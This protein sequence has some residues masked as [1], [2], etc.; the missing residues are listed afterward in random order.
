MEGEKALEVYCLVKMS[1]VDG[2][3]KSVCERSRGE[4]LGAWRLGW[5][6]TQ[7]L[8]ALIVGTLAPRVEACV[9]MEHDRGR[10]QGTIPDPAAWPSQVGCPPGL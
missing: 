6:G 4:R 10:R 5:G 9:L 8:G 7:G 2:N 1:V 3:R